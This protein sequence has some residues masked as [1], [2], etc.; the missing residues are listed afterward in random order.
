MLWTSIEYKRGV[1]VT[2]CTALS[3]LHSGYKGLGLSIN[4]G[5]HPHTPHLDRELRGARVVTRG[6]LD[7]LLL[8]QMVAVI[9]LYIYMYIY[10][11]ICIYIYIYIYIHTYINI[12]IYNVY[13]FIYVYILYIYIYI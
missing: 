7:F 8:Y 3:T 12:Y 9:Y 2:P 1:G 10:I 11:Y 6:V 5:E 13:I 4:S